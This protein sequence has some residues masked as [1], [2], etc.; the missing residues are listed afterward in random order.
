MQR[1]PSSTD[2]RPAPLRAGLAAILAAAV[3][4]G[5][6][7]TARAGEI[8][9]SAFAGGEGSSWRGD[10]AGFVGLR[11]G[12]RFVDLVGPYV[13]FRA[14]YAN[15][16]ERIL[17]LV[18]IGGQIWARIGITRP[19]LRFG[20]VHQHEEPWASVKSDVLGGLI[21]VGDG[22]RH[23][24]GFDGAL[25]VDLPFKQYKHFQFHATLEAVVSGFPDAK[26]PRFYGGAISGIGFNYS[27]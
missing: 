9:L 4:L 18:Q 19:Y 7:G 21:G 8:Q 13:M 22:I 16:D 20:L 15:V 3:V 1:S 14:G 5:G 11:L 17:E 25:G 24:M 6:S 26:G 23:R 12:F 10:G 27:L 2:R